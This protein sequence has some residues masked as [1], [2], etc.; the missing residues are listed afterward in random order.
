MSLS[1]AA[2]NLQIAQG[3]FGA[4]SSPESIGLPVYSSQSSNVLPG[5]SSADLAK[6]TPQQQAALSDEVLQL[7]Q[8]QGLFSEPGT[9]KSTFSLLA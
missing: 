9:A 2:V 8:A 1:D 6:A 5:V 7:Q 3:L 4:P